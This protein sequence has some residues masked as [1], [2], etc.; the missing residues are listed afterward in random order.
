M[1]DVSKQTDH[2]D[3]NTGAKHEEGTPPTIPRS[4]S[5]DQGRAI[6]K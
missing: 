5:G 2:S 1:R 4:T 3:R 6:F